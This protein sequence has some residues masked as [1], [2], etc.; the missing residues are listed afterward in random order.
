MIPVTRKAFLEAIKSVGGVS[1][2]TLAVEFV[3]T[4]DEIKSVASVSHAISPLGNDLLTS[5]KDFRDLILDHGKTRHYTIRPS[6]LFS[7]AVL[8]EFHLLYRKKDLVSL[9][10]RR[11]IVTH[12]EF[13]VGSG[14]MRLI[15]PENGHYSSAEWERFLE[16][17]M[18]TPCTYASSASTNDPIKG[19]WLVVPFAG[20]NLDQ[21]SLFRDRSKV[22]SEKL[23]AYEQNAEAIKVDDQ[24]STIDAHSTARRRLAVDAQAICKAIRDTSVFR[25]ILNDF[26]HNLHTAGINYRFRGGSPTFDVSDADKLSSVKGINDEERF[27]LYLGWSFKWASEFKD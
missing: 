1:L 27:I 6:Y 2:Q 17:R 20:Q 11:V 23:S 22:L 8:A 26:A 18:V 16:S 3:R 15:V 13:V 7:G 25:E 9:S 21:H 24:E 10:V 5:F 12:D 19:E 14:G 4:Y